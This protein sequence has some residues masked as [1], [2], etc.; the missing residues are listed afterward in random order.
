MTTWNPDR[1]LGNGRIDVFDNNGRFIDELDDADDKR[2]SS[3]AVGLD[4]GR[5]PRGFLRRF[6]K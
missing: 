3:M 5:R 6:K 2:W 4:L 1:Q